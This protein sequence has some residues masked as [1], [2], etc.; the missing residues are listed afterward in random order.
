MKKEFSNPDGYWDYEG[1]YSI[2]LTEDGGKKGIAL[3]PDN[4][5]ITDNVITIKQGRVYQDMG[6]IN[7]YC[8]GRDK[9][10]SIGYSFIKCIR[11][12]NGDLLWVNNNFR[13]KILK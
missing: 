1:G 7:F 4:G 6:G 12:D 9:P 3:P 10:F 11:K 2:E 8:V 5:S 13:E